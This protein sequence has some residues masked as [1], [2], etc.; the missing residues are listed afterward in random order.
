MEMESKN[1][2]AGDSIKEKI[3]GTI[4]RVNAV[5]GTCVFAENL[6]YGYVQRLEFDQFEIEK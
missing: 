6:E 1:V 2:K 3:G 4:Y 5:L